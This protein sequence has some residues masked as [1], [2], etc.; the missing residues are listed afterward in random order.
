LSD[1]A[2]APKMMWS[3]WMTDVA[4]CLPGVRIVMDIKPPRPGS[5]RIWG[6]LEYFDTADRALTWES[7]MLRTLQI[8]DVWVRNQAVI[9]QSDSLRR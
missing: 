2:L 4:L 5:I 3:A 7:I 6:K 1:L 9:T 8:G